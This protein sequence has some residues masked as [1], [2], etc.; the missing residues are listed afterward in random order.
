MVKHFMTKTIRLMT[1]KGQNRAGKPVYLIR[2]RE[3]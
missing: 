3:F 1:D 2:M